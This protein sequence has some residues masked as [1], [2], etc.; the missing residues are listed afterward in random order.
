MAM[1]TLGVSVHATR[2][3][4]QDP[5]LMEWWIGNMVVA[6]RNLVWPMMLVFGLAGSL[7]L[8]RFVITK[9]L[10]VVIIVFDLFRF[11]WKYTP[12]V[13]KDWVYP[14]TEVLSWLADREGLFRVESKKGPFLPANT[15]AMYGLD[16]ASGYDPL[17]PREYVSEY[18][19]QLNHS[20]SE[21]RYSIL[22]SYD[23]TD[24]GE[25]NIK[26]LLDDK[27]HF[28]RGVADWDVAYETDKMQVLENPE[29]RPRIGWEA[30]G[31]VGEIDIL[32]YEAQEIGIRY[33]A[34]GPAR[35]IVRDS[36][37]EGWR[38][39]VNGEEQSIGKYRNVFRSIL[40]PAGEGEVVMRYE[41]KEWKLA[42]NLAAVGLIS[43]LLL[44]IKVL[45]KDKAI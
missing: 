3:F 23:P 39:W 28:T 19:L 6:R 35:M 40:V 11:G 8:R 26:Y 21:S 43:W 16:A 36:W 34:S 37:D 31:D 41:P 4:G 13:D 42:K 33:K 10:V 32:K 24:L 14:K 44:G 27:E 1:I 15:W 2:V 7:V 38:A 29:V 45:R 18:S 22:E 5:G 20:N 9:W 12:F 25:F 30:D 17:A